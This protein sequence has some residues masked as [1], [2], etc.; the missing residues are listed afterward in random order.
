VH[1]LRQQRAASILP[2]ILRN[3]S[4]GRQ[5][6]NGLE[7]RTAMFAIRGSFNL[8]SFRRVSFCGQG[9]PQLLSYFGKALK[10]H[11]SWA[12][13]SPACVAAEK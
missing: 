13:N 10:M 4:I 2:A 11:P 3:L 5:R 1:P 7:R 9:C 8:P 6:D 12:N